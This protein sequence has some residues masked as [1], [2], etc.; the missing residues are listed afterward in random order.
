MFAARTFVHSAAFGFREL[1]QQRAAKI[2]QRIINRSFGAS[3]NL[4]D[5]RRDSAGQRN[6]HLL[7]GW[8]FTWNLALG[9]FQFR[10]F[11]GESR[12]NCANN[13]SHDVVL[14]VA[15]DNL[16]NFG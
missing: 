16:L 3:L 6:G 9:R 4:G 1:S 12:V 5:E 8:R 14:F 10:L 7:S 11:S 2:C 13:V 15:A